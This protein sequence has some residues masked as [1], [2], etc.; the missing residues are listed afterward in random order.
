MGI[1]PPERLYPPPPFHRDRPRGA[2]GRGID[3]DGLFLELRG[4]DRP[5]RLTHAGI[6][7]KNAGVVRLHRVRGWWIFRRVRPVDVTI[8]RPDGSK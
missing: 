7:W 1:V 5:D 4:R 2:F 6:V 3:P 8:Y